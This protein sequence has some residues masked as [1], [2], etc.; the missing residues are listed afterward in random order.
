MSRGETH[1]CNIV[2]STTGSS[3]LPSGDKTTALFNAGVGAFAVFNTLTFGPKSLVCPASTFALF[4]LIPMTPPCA[5]S[6]RTKVGEYPFAK[7]SAEVVD[8]EDFQLEVAT[9]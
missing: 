4:K 1:F 3:N 5:S 8:V 2:F 9:S 6:D 7:L